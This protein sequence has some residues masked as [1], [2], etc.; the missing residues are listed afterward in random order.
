MPTMSSASSPSTRFLKLHDVSAGTH[1]KQAS[2]IVNF[3]IVGAG[4]AGLACAIALRRVGHR[5]IVL[6]KNAA[7]SGQVRNRLTLCRLVDSEAN[8]DTDQ[9]Y[10]AFRGNTCA[11]EPHENP[12]SL[13]FTKGATFHSPEF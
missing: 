5:V 10:Q 3:L 6:E 13:G 12:V 7:I 2:L 1:A 11:T 9:H 8:T 4:L